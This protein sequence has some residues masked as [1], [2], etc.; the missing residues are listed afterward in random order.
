MIIAMQHISSRP[1]DGKIHNVAYVE[2]DGHLSTTNI[3]LYIFV[4]IER[5]LI[6]RIYIQGVCANWFGSFLHISIVTRT[7]THS[8]YYIYTILW[9]INLSHAQW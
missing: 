9:E 7:W 6:N 1:D 3:I 4:V 2:P 8:A 5:T